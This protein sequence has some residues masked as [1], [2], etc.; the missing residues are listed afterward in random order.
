[1]LPDDRAVSAVMLEWDGGIASALRPGAV[2]VDMSSSNP[3]GTIKLGK[4]LAE[5]GDRLRRRPGLGR[6]R[7]A[8]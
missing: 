7:R 2:L 4:A 6:H 5:R 1:M 8:P 3:N